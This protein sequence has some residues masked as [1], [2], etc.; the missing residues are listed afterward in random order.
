[1]S[2]ENLTIEQAS[3]VRS[4]SVGASVSFGHETFEMTLVAFHLRKNEHSVSER[5]SPDL[6]DL[7]RVFQIDHC[8][9]ERLL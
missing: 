8:C 9:I 7:D 4:T 3:M 6:A 5:T 1:M 2:F